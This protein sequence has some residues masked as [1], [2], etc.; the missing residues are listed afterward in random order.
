MQRFVVRFANRRRW[1]RDRALARFASTMP[2]GREQSRA[3][4]FEKAVEVPAGS[5]AVATI[6]R[7]SAFKS[8]KFHHNGHARPIQIGQ[9][10]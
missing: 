3:T 4:Q 10:Y 7:S 2:F 6:A 8:M 9:R 1:S 5:S